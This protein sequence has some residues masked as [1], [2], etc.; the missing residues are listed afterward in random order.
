MEEGIGGSVCSKNKLDG[1][2]E[3]VQNDCKPAMMYA[4]ETWAVKKS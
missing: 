1:Q 2:G 3:S 4:A